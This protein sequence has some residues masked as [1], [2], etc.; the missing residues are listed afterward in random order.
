MPEAIQVRED[1]KL[2]TSQASLPGWNGLGWKRDILI[3]GPPSSRFVLAPV[4]QPSAPAV[5]DCC[6]AATRQHH[7]R[8][9]ADLLHHLSAKVFPA[10]VHQRV[11]QADAVQRHFINF[12]LDTLLHQLNN[13]RYTDIHYH[14]RSERGSAP[15]RQA[16]VSTCKSTSQPLQKICARTSEG[17]LRIVLRCRPLQ[18]GL[19]AS[20]AVLTLLG[21]AAS[22]RRAQAFG[23]HELH[24]RAQCLHLRKTSSCRYAHCQRAL[25]T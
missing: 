19:A 11:Q 7:M 17:W 13:Q 1:H 9:L 18:T 24:C 8:K 12:A 16:K 20:M 23:A 4:Q 2:T 14:K 10:A 21:A 25:R 3:F 5:S 6:I 22:L 15:A